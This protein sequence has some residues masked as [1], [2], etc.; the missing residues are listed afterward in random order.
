MEC[1]HEPCFIILSDPIHANHLALVRLEVHIVIPF[2]RFLV[3]YRH[4]LTTTLPK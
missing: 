3:T 1:G 4:L 2:L